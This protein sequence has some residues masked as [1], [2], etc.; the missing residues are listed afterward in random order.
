MT[1]TTQP[2]SF[3]IEQIIDR[4]LDLREEVDEAEATHKAAVAA[5][6][7]AM[8]VIEKH[9]M[10]VCNKTGQTQFGT[11]RATAFRTTVTGCKVQDWE[12][13]KKYIQENNAWHLLNKAVNKTAVADHIEQNKV[14]PPGVGWTAIYEFKIRRKQSANE[15]VE[16]EE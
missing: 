7:E 12:A 8:S 1:D 2:P 9:L 6:K 16:I 3:T 15:K 5:K 13:T 4:Y 14:P 11:E 10:S